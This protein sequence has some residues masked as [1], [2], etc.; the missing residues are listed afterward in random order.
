MLKTIILLMS[1]ITGMVLICSCIAQESKIGLPSPELDK[2]IS[3]EK[4]FSKRR[5]VREY[6]NQTLDFKQISQLLWAAQGI[7]SDWGGRTAPSAGA[8]YPIEMYLVVNNSEELSPGVY[9]YENSD[10]SL[11]LVKK[12]STGKKLSQASLG[13]KS[14]E[15]A[16]I[17]IIITAVFQRTE[18]RYG[19]RA[20]RYVFMEA[21]HVGQNIYLQAESLGLGTVVIGAFHDDQVKEVLG[22]DENV[23]AIMPVGRKK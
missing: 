10:H 19:K 7:T 11:R 16:P 8:T 18:N 9:Y 14:I 1:V 3:V 23:I 6:S 13:Q 4:A 12:G 21:G 20:E 5:S 2:G 17:N 15:E 22:I